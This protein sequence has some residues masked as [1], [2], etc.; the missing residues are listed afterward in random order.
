MDDNVVF[1]KANGAYEILIVEDDAPDQVIVEK[2]IKTLWPNSKTTSAKCL[3]DAL[4]ILKTRSFDIVL[5]DL[6]LRDALGPR[7][8]YELRK[9]APK[10]PLIVMTGMLNAITADESLKFGANNIVSKSQV[11]EADFLNILEQNA[12]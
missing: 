6:N 8:V 4:R 10:V 12:S 9:I 7:T 3:R 2:Q 1:R 11:A 5:L